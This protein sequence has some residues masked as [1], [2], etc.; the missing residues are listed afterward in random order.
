MF[1]RLNAFNETTMDDHAAL[2]VQQALAQP[3]DPIIEE[4]LTEM[5]ADN[6]REAYMHV[7]A[8]ALANFDLSKKIYAIGCPTLVISGSDDRVLPPDGGCKIGASNTRLWVSF[9]RRCL[10]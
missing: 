9:D 7:L 8:G 6:D 4:W 5:I 1:A 10:R 2:V 3:P